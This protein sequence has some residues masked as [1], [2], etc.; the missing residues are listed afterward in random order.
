[1]FEH[2]RVGNGLRSLRRIDLV[3]FGTAF[4]DPEDKRATWWEKEGAKLG[5]VVT[6]RYAK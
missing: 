5:I 6:R 3:F 4:I 1:V 2:V